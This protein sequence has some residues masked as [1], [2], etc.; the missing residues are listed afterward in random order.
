MKYKIIRLFLYLF[1]VLTTSC[2]F[3]IVNEKSNQNFSITE[4]YTS[5]DNRISFKIKNN[6]IADVVKDNTNKIKIDLNTRKKKIIKEKNIKNE[7]TKYEIQL[8]TRLY[9]YKIDTGKRFEINISNSGDYIIGA[10]YSNTLSNEKKL[11]EDLVDNISKKII[12]EI[13]ILFDDI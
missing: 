3:K 12:K 5:G 10:N 7:V 8:N 9:I 11:V 4:I 1:L 13:S 2:G 6:L